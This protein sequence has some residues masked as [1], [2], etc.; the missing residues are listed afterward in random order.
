MKRL[1]VVSRLGAA[2]V[3]AGLILSSGAAYAEGDENPAV[4]YRA[5]VMD[6]IL[7]NSNY[8]FGMLTGKVEYDAEQAQMRAANIKALASMPWEA[9][10][11]DTQGTASSALDTV[12]SDPEGFQA[13]AAAF[14]EAVNE[15]EAAAGEGE[16]AAK[17]A[18]AKMGGTC[19]KC[20][21]TYRQK[22]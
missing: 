11:A 2:V 13:A 14:L 17:L 15:L 8:F 9:F 10:G 1:N 18:G 6:A 19:S 20:H 3:S 12:W 16:S 7:W 21:D 5:S 4:S 22:D